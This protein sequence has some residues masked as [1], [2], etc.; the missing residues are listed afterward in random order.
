MFTAFKCP[1]YSPA[2][3]AIDD[4]QHYSD[5]GDLYHGRDSKNAE[6]TTT[7]NSL[8]QRGK[9]SQLD[10]SRLQITVKWF[11]FFYPTQFKCLILAT[12]AIIGQKNPKQKQLAT[13][14]LQLVQAVSPLFTLSVNMPIFHIHLLWMTTS[15]FVKGVQYEL[16]DQWSSQ[17]CFA[18]FHISKVWLQ[19]R[20][21]NVRWEG[22]GWVEKRENRDIMKI[23]M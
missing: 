20:R 10:F 12:M 6:S 17:A 7:F 11:L 1:P 4:H 9:I 2:L 18:F 5:M 15:N 3:D 14:R 23:Y 8:W 19:F 22:R 16:M 21:W 13:V